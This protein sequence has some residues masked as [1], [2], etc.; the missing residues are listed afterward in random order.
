MFLHQKFESK[1]FSILMDRLQIAQRGAFMHEKQEQMEDGGI[2][3]V[4]MDREKV[5]PVLM[6]R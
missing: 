1:V 4:L 5:V 3:N 2:F 6:E